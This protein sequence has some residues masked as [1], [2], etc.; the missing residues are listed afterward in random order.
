M[1]LFVIASIVIIN[2]ATR[3]ITVFYAKQV[4]GNKMYGGQSTHL[5]L[6]L[7]QAGVI[8]IIFAVSLVLLPS[9]IANYLVVAKEPILHN[10]GTS[11]TV[12]L[13]PSGFLYNA[14]YFILVVGFTYFYTAVVFNPKKIADEIQKYGGF[15]PGI[16][17]G[18]PTAG[19]L[20]YILTR[21]TLAGALFLGFIAIFPTI[22]KFFTN[23]Q[24][25]VLG[26]TG[27]LIVVSVVLET[28]KAIEAQLVMR[29]YE[30][31]SKK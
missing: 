18:A 30:G 20:N 1:A 5:P 31:F 12:W 3:Q 24:N 19:Y 25:L 4:R 22:A 26:G 17:P 11:I 13:N 2:E 6:R 23:I 9:L 27:I 14:I 7:N 28:I 29:N 15:I 16:R 10:I 21:I 8:P